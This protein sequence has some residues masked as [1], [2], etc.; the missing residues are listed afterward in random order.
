M[1]NEVSVVTFPVR[2]FRPRRTLCNGLRSTEGPDAFFLTQVTPGK[3]SITTVDDRSNPNCDSFKKRY[4][5]VLPK[6][7][8][9]FP[10]FYLLYYCIYIFLFLFN[11]RNFQ[12]Y[13]LIK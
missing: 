10:F 9:I 8:D 12:L 3:V 1:S 11:V 6:V 5:L 2:N 4:T 13:R 7:Q